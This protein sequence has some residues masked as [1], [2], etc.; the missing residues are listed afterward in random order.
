IIRKVKVEPQLPPHQQAMLDIDHIKNEK[1]WQHELSKEYYTQLT[2]T[3]RTYIEKRFG[4]K[5]LEMTTDEIVEK[6][7][8]IPDAEALQEL[9]GLLKTA[10][11]VKFAK[12]IPLM[13]E[14]DA[15]LLYA[16][17]FINETKEIEDPNAKPAPTEI[18]I[19]EKRP[20]RTKVLLGIGI[21]LISIFLIGALVYIGMELYNN[22]A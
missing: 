12:F 6:L 7:E 2:D 5:A 14:N 10:D 17:K 1:V 3:L 8:R 13:N 20:L 19:I 16:V 22:L 21:L 18:T 9:R 11:L 4:F 15:N